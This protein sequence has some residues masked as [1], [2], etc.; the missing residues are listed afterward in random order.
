MP[1]SVRS[2]ARHGEHHPHSAAGANGAWL[3]EW[4]GAGRACHVLADFDCE[5]AVTWP[6]TVS[7]VRIP[8]DGRWT[9]ADRQE[10]DGS[11]L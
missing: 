5:V 2:S 7:R 6:R 1:I 9:P 11:W 4:S 3:G 10:A 8:R